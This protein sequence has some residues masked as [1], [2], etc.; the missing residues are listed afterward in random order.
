MSHAWCTAPGLTLLV[1]SGIEW[2]DIKHRA[3][4]SVLMSLDW[5]FGASALAG[6]AYYVRDWRYLTMA[7]TTPLFL[8]VP[9]WW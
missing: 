8:A 9:T 1:S 3:A 4:V 2:M 7:A 5:S 6:I